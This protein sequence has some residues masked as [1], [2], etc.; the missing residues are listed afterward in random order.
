MGVTAEEN[1]CSHCASEVLGLEEITQRNGVTDKEAQ[2]WP[3]SSRG[4]AN[5]NE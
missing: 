5:K 2:D 1:F 4:G 3:L